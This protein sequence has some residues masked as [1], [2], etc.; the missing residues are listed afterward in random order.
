MYN[1]KEDFWCDGVL[2]S[3]DWATYTGSSLI[4]EPVLACTQTVPDISQIEF[5]AQFLL[6]S[7]QLFSPWKTSS[8]FPGCLRLVV[9]QPNANKERT[10]WKSTQVS[11]LLQNLIIS[12]LL[13]MT[14]TAM[15]LH[16][17]H[18]SV[19]MSV[20]EAGSNRLPVYLIMSCLCVCIWQTL[21]SKATYKWG[22]NITANI[23]ANNKLNRR[24]TTNQ[25]LSEVTGLTV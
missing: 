3:F 12:L 6:E 15:G 7:V 23:K 10:T 19:S 11:F 14:N 1:T 8:V 5:V 21:L 4:W 24:K 9:S 22:Y 25:A 20:V 17:L 2:S 13:K 18:L 16:R